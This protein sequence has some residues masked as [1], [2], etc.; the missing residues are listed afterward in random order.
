MPTRPRQSRKGYSTVSDDATKGAALCTCIMN[1]LTI[2]DTDED[3]N[4]EQE[5][6]LA[7]EYRG[8]SNS[9]SDNAARRG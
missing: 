1:L 9:E 6:Q 3:D 8:H 5:A 4:N 7:M 2:R